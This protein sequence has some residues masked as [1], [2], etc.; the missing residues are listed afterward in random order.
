MVK[1][2]FETRAALAR[3]APTQK[4]FALVFDG[5]TLGYYASPT[6]AAEESA[7]GT[8]FWP[9]AGDPSKMDIPDNIGEWQRVP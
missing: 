5:E 7:N 3:I 4:G 9:S 6:T 2:V 8:R 1:W